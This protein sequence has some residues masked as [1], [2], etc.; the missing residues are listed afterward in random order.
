MD[1]TS[2]DIQLSEDQVSKARRQIDPDLLKEKSLKD[3]LKSLRNLTGET[4]ATLAEMLGEKKR[5]FES[6]VSGRYVPEGVKLKK[7][8]SILIYSALIYI[9][10]VIEEKIPLNIY[11][12]FPEVF[13]ILDFNDAVVLLISFFEKKGKNVDYETGKIT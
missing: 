6:W 10:S 2:F 8:N 13:N 9:N 4:N 12:N 11:K 1:L 5:T 3:K 7:V